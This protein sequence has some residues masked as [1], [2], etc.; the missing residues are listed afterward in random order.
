MI[1]STPKLGEDNK[2]VDNN[3]ESQKDYFIEH[4]SYSAIREP[5]NNVSAFQGYRKPASLP[6]KDN[7]MTAQ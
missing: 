4:K 5:A 2:N 3:S 1:P 6:K 7:I